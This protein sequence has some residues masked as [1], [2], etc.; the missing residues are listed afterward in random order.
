MYDLDT[1]SRPLSGEQNGPARPPGLATVSGLASLLAPDAANTPAGGG[2]HG[3]VAAAA[4][5][6]PAAQSY[7]RNRYSSEPYYE[8]GRS[9]EDYAPAYE[10][11]ASVRA[12]ATVDQEFDAL[13]PDMQRAWESRGAAS[14]LT[15][16]EVRAAMR[17]AWNRVD[18]DLSDVGTR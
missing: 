14:N 11:G 12:L 1:Q 15:W 3:Q 18:V 7:W 17:A 16:E 4:G 10:L 6:A 5:R 13:E 9:F 8:P 2:Q